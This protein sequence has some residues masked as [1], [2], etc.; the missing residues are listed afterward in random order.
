MVAA[1]P[2]RIAIPEPS[3]CGSLPARPKGRRALPPERSRQLS[4]VQ[5]AID[6]RDAQVFHR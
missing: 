3:R 1:S 5:D 4:G 6:G 2:P